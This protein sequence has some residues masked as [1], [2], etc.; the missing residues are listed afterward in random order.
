[1]SPKSIFLVNFVLDKDLNE[2][3]VISS[4]ISRYKFIISRY[5]FIISRYKFITSRYKFIISSL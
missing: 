2:L 1:M 4:I 3:V 5:K